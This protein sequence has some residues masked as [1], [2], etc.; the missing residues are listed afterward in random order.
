[1]QL[2][3]R[4]SVRAPGRI[5]LFGEHQDYLDLPVIA[6]A[7]DR[8]IFIRGSR[9]QDNEFHIHLTDLGKTEQFPLASHLP[10]QHEKDYFRSGLNVVMRLGVNPGCGWDCN[11]HGT[12]PINAG[13]SSS[14][15]LMVA[16]ILFLLT[17]AGDARADDPGFVAELAFQAEVAE[18]NQPGGRMDQYTSSFGGVIYLD[19]VTLQ[20]ETLTARPGPFIL[21][22]SRQPKS[23]SAILASVKRDAQAAAAAITA[24]IPDFHFRTTSPEA[25]QPFLSRLSP[26]QAELLRA[27]LIDFQLLSEALY[28]LRSRETDLEKLG[29]LLNRHHE[30][31]RDRKGISTE[32]IDAM[33]AASLEAGALGGKINGS[34]GGGCM[35]ALAAG[36][37]EHV[38]A[39][40]RAQGGV[41]HLLTIDPGACVEEIGC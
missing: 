6:V 30:Q 38:A 31:L 5:C 20:T 8:H 15:A 19:P 23:T 40:I 39:A 2:P 36:R 29:H 21:G 37:E 1:M 11:V 22:D 25:V 24:F 34:G 4:I 17:A 32:K 35:F 27:N 28:L 3:R 16:W 41:P 14:S 33:L 13:T 7:I 10:C 9:R 26:R 12:I 18:F